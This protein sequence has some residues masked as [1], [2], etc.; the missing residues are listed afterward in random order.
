MCKLI[1][2]QEFRNKQKNTMR[3]YSTGSG[4]QNISLKIAIVEW[5][6][7]TKGILLQWQWRNTT[8]YNKL[9]VKLNWR[10]SY[11]IKL[12]SSFYS[13]IYSRA[14]SQTLAWIRIMGWGERGL[15]KPRFLGL[16]SKGF[17]SGGLGQG[18]IICNSSMFSGDADGPGPE[19]PL[20]EPLPKVDSVQG[21]MGAIHC[22]SAPQYWKLWKQFTSPQS[23]WGRIIRVILRNAITT[24]QF[25]I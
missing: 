6:H 19:T 15:L 20:W 21:D 12:R 14:G 25:N 4:C 8:F 5:E 1:S 13:N 2:N 22:G 24:Q 18:S 16:K 17:D 10:F 7:K 3:D 11:P 23:L 9:K